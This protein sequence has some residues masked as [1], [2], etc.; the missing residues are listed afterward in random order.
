MTSG[1][2]HEFGAGHAAIDLPSNR[3]F[4]KVFGAIFAIYAVYLARH[5]NIFWI[6]GGLAAVI[7]AV[8]G[9]RDAAWLTPL[10]RLWMRLGLLL[11]MIVAP[12]ALAVLFFLVITPIGLVAQ[13][14]G[15]DFLRTKRDTG[16]TS[17]WIY[18]DP[19]GP[20]AKSMNRQF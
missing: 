19:P 11:S 17:Y 9:F 1:S 4:G 7:F 5:G 2:H 3:S 14:F 16:K 10:N 18:R 13:V 20:D 15:K 6:V 8:A 12:V